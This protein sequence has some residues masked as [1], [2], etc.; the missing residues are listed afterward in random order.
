MR[1]RYHFKCTVIVLLFFSFIAHAEIPPIKTLWHGVRGKL[2][3]KVQTCQAFL[4]AKGHLSLSG[5]SGQ[6]YSSLLDI[7][8]YLKRYYQVKTH[9]VQP[10]LDEMAITVEDGHLLKRSDVKEILGVLE[11]LDSDMSHLD[12]PA[13]ALAYEVRGEEDIG[14]LLE[15]IENLSHKKR[16]IIKKVKQRLPHWFNKHNFWGFSLMLTG[17][18]GAISGFDLNST[19]LNA[20]LFYS[21]FQLS[22]LKGLNPNFV[23]FHS[24][25][26]LA[27]IHKLLESRSDLSNPFSIVSHNIEISEKF[28]EQLMQLADQANYSPSTEAIEAIEATEPIEHTEAIED[29]YLWQLLDVI[30]RKLALPTNLKIIMKEEYKKLEKIL[31]DPN[32]LDDEDKNFLQRLSLKRQRA[33]ITQVFFLD[34]NDQPVWL[35]FYRF[36]RTPPSYPKKPKRDDKTRS[37][38]FDLNPIWW[39]PAPVKIP[40]RSTAG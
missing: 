18:L 25:S 15:S 8:G 10:V 14:H 24:S 2:P 17:I 40:S 11:A 13:I 9:E 33:N 20:S 29:E 3:L 34:E 23:D 26:H 1:V 7:Q 27:L 21:F 12:G 36:F 37:R 38:A 31:E 32:N 22:T 16:E 30:D 5:L 19:L 4:E 28:H 6:A 39:A 35:L